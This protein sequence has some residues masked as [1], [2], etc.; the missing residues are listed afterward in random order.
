M[1]TPSQIRNRERL[2][3]VFKTRN[4]KPLQ[5]YLRG[6]DGVGHCFLGLCYEAMRISAPH[7]YHWVDT[8]I[9]FSLESHHTIKGCVK[10]G[11]HLKEWL[12]VEGGTFIRMT[13]LNDSGSFSWGEL[14]EKFEELLKEKDR[15]TDTLP[16]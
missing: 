8:R 1:I 11:D 7:L 10:A 5:Y 6:K 13:S 3:K 4:D 2:E 14:W 15:A 9:I 12:G 16:N